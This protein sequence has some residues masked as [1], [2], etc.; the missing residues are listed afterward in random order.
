M[1]SQEKIEICLKCFA[2]FVEVFRGYQPYFKDSDSSIWAD[3]GRRMPRSLLKHA[4]LCYLRFSQM[5]DEL[6]AD[7]ENEESRVIFV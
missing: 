4:Y 6:E 7:G 5:L 3:E 1:N 2:S